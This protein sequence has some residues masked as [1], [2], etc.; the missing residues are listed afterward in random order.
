MSIKLFIGF[1][2]LFVGCIELLSYIKMKE[3]FN[4]IEEIERN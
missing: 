4:N 1:S 3:H 2:F